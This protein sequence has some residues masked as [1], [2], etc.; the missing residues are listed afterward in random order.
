MMSNTVCNGLL[1][2][3][4]FLPFFVSLLRW[5]KVQAVSSNSTP[6]FNLHFKTQVPLFVMPC[7]WIFVPSRLLT[8]VWAQP[9]CGVLCL[10]ATTVWWELWGFV[11]TAADSFPPVCVCLCER[12]ALA[13]LLVCVWS[14][15]CNNL[16][17]CDVYTFPDIFKSIPLWSLCPGLWRGKL[18]SVREHS[19]GYFQ[20]WTIW[21]GRMG[22]KNKLLG[23]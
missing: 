22:Q 3:Y 6:F 18:W 19:E 7:S 16:W 8:E 20:F 13:V 1:S 15:S 5:C 11:E 2:S 9:T 4:D 23:Y 21:K 14:C 10:V 12:V 17:V